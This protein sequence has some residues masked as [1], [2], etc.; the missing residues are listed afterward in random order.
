M[1][2]IKLNN[3]LRRYVLSQGRPTC[4]VLLGEIFD[5]IRHLACMFLFYHQFSLKVF[6]FYLQPVTLYDLH[7]Q[8]QN[9]N[10]SKSDVKKKQTKK[11]KQKKNTTKNSKISLCTSHC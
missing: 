10:A 8:F 3:R 6:F 5:A 9:S 2:E 7:F 4:S 1:S 11:P